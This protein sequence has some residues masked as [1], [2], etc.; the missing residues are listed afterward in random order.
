[1]LPTP[2]YNL[3]VCFICVRICSL[4]VGLQA[5]A[6]AQMDSGYAGYV[7]SATACSIWTKVIRLIF[8]PLP[9]SLLDGENAACVHTYVFPPYR[10]LNWTPVLRLMS[11]SLLHAQ[12]DGGYAELYRAV[13]AFLTEWEGLL[14][15]LQ[16]DRY[17]MLKLRDL[18]KGDR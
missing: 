5:V 14:G 8:P 9:L 4:R 17:A 15:T 12:L 7:P 18:H 6:I 13:L 10:F 1:V 16:T 2:L 11:P 3:F